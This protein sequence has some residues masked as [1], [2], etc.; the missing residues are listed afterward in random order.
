MHQRDAICWRPRSSPA[1]IRDM[2]A[3]P[4]VSHPPRPHATYLFPKD[5]GIGLACPVCKSSMHRDEQRFICQ[6]ESCRRSYAIRDGIPVLLESESTVLSQ[7]D[8]KAATEPN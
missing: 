5:P 7:T 2:S 6:Q 4:S 3:R 1:L 8:W